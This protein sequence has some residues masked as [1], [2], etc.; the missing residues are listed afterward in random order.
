MRAAADALVEAVASPHPVDAHTLEE[1]R[2]NLARESLQHLS[3]EERQVQTPLEQH[4]DAGIRAIALRFREDAEA[5][6]TQFRTHV[7]DWPADTIPAKWASYGRSVRKLVARLHDRLDR[8]ERELY[9]LVARSNVKEA[10][11]KRNWAGDAWSLRKS[12][13]RGD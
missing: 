12:I 10:A 3:L 6:S 1:L 4:A 2:W 13:R 7:S 9:P 8:E 11:P 5:F